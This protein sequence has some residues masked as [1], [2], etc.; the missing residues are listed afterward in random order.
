MRVLAPN[1]VLFGAV[2]K[3]ARPSCANDPVKPKLTGAPKTNA[4][5]ETG[6]AV[7]SPVAPEPGH[8]AMTSSVVESTITRA[9]AERRANCSRTVRERSRTGM[10]PELDAHRL[11]RLVKLLVAHEV[12][13]RERIT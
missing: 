4:G 1:A 11:A 10:F 8:T 7:G 5:G 6:S 12:L 13:T 2:G 3:G 9:G